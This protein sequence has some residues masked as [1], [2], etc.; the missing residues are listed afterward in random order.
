MLVVVVVVVVFNCVGCL[1]FL[2]VFLRS[3]LQSFMSYFTLGAIGSEG[4]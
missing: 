4:S 1:F 2:F 3:G